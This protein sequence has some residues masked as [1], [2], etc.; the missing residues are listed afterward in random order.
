MNIA[1]NRKE[2]LDAYAGKPRIHKELQQAYVNAVQDIVKF[3]DAKVVLYPSRPECVS[4]LV[5]DLAIGR[6]RRSV[7]N[8][9]H[10]LEKTPDNADLMAKLQADGALLVDKLRNLKV[11]DN[12]LTFTENKS[13]LIW[14]PPTDED[15]GD[16]ELTV[17]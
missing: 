12:A 4:F 6:L 1:I 7:L 8:K 9:V 15:D 16:R 11:N 17:P 2:A 13:P 3:V 5:N 10:D 14:M